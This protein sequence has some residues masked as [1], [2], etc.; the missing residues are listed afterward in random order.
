MSER[1]QKIMILGPTA[2]GKTELAHSLALQLDGEI[3]SVDSRQC[4]KR[5]DIGTAKP[6]QKLLREVRY[7]NISMLDLTESDSAVSFAQRAAEWERKIVS[8]GKT[9]IYAGGSTLHLQS[10]LQPFDDVPESSTENLQKLEREADK[11]GL[12]SLF[13]KLEEV[14]PEYASGMDGFNRQRI[15]RALDVW[16]QTGK[17]FSSFHQKKEIQPPSDMNVF[18]LKWP[19]KVLHERIN[20]RVDQMVEAGLVDET[21]QILNDGYPAELQ[22]LQTVGYRDVIRYLDGEVSFEQMIADIKTQ[23]RRYAKRQITWFRR[24]PFIQWMNAH[25][26]DSSEMIEVVKQGLAANLN[27]G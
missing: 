23:T 9:V 8:S 12:E 18:G 5:I 17:P 22:S 16:M 4:Y 11:E 27:K 20:R 21:K 26:L 10:L 19:R 24:W 3:I 14:D 7:Y 15:F 1:N 13:Q 25:E 6:D 2:S